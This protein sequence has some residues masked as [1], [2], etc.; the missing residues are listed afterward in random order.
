MQNLEKAQSLI[1]DL[2][3][4]VKQLQ[5]SASVSER[6]GGELGQLQREMVLLGEMQQRHRDRFNQLPLLAQHHEEATR[7]R[8]AC[9]EDIAGGTLQLRG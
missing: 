2:S 9:R 7:L 8:D 5:E 3:S 6:L 4:E 1:F